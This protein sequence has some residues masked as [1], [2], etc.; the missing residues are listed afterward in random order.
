MMRR[1]LDR[2]GEER[3][4]YAAAPRKGGRKDS[5]QSLIRALNIVNRIATSDDGLTLT[6]IAEDVDLAVST[7]HRLLT[8]LEQ[9]RFVQFDAERRRWLIGVQ[10]FVAGSAFLKTRNLVAVARPYMRALMEECRETVNLAV[11]DK[12]NAMYVSQSEGPQS[13]QALARTG[14]KVPL[15]C[16]GVGKAM[17]AGKSDAELAKFLP[18]DGKRRLTANTIVSGSSLHDDI[19]LA[20]ERAYA[21]DNEEHAI[22]LVCVAAPVFNEFREPMGAISISGPVARILKADIPRLGDLARRRADQITA[23]LGGARPA[24]FR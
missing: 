7:V 13:A 9:E 21:V 24:H 16:S 19:M 1:I 15:H 10:T 14:A 22:G 4:E 17:L 20:R 11:E 12:G 5:V 18:G 8:T 2:P 3:S 23:R 6:R